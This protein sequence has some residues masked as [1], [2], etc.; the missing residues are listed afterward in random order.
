MLSLFKK[1]TRMLQTEAKIIEDFINVHAPFLQTYNPR[2][3]FVP[4]VPSHETTNHKKI[5]TYNLT[6]EECNALKEQL[7]PKAALV[8]GESEESW[9]GKI[10]HEG[11]MIG[12]YLGRSYEYETFWARFWLEEVNS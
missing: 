5:V 3:H 4:H 12:V 6:E 7:L 2:H 9:F 11:Q 8:T 1:V 10:L